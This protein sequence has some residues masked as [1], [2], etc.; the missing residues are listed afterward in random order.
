MSWG[1]TDGTLLSIDGTAMPVPSK[2]DLT[3]QDLSASDAGRNMDGKMFKSKIDPKGTARTIDLEWKAK[4]QSEGHTILEALGTNEYM[5]VSFFDYFKGSAE[6]NIWMYAGDRKCSTHFIKKIGSGN[7][8]SVNPVYT[9][10]CTLI[11]VD[12]VNNSTPGTGESSGGSS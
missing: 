5:Q 3:Y 4:Q 12:P 2:Y 10:T 6:S 11:E 7:N 1:K 8:S 9:I